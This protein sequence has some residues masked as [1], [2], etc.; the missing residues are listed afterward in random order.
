MTM[1]FKKMGS[2]KA[3]G[4]YY[5][6]S[7]GQDPNLP[8]V[9]RFKE[10]GVD[11]YYQQ[12][13]G[14]EPNGVFLDHKGLLEPYGINHGDE[15]S[16]S[17]FQNLLA[18]RDPLNGD[19]LTGSV[20]E[21]HVAGF[22]CTMSAP[23]PFSALKALATSFERE[24][25]VDR[26]LEIANKA[27]KQSIQFLSENAGYTRRGKGGKIFE[28]VDLISAQWQHSTSRAAD[29]QLHFHNTVFN[30]GFRKDG[31]VGA[32]ESKR[33]MQWQTAAGAVFRAELATGL[34]KEFPEIEIIINEEKG[35]FEIEGINEDLIKFWSK[36][37]NEIEDQM[38][39]LKQSSYAAADRVTL[40]TRE[41][42]TFEESPAELDIR[43]RGEAERF[44]VNTQTLDDILTPTNIKIIDKSPEEKAVLEKQLFEDKMNSVPGLLVENESV[45]TEQQLYRKVAELS[46]GIHDLEDIKKTVNRLMH[47]TQTEIVAQVELKSVANKLTKG[48]V[49]DRKSVK[50]TVRDEV[51]NSQR[52][53]DSVVIQ[54]GENKKG[55]RIFTTLAQVRLEADL[56]KRSHE[57]SNDSTHVVDKKTIEHAITAKSTMS[58]E[59]ADAVRWA[60]SPGSLK[61][62]EGGAGT[63][64]SFSLDVVRQISEENGYKLHGIALSWQAAGVLEASASISSVAITG[65]LNDVEN[66]Q[67]K[68]NNKSILV[69]DENGL[70]GTVYGQK[71]LK[72]VQEAGAK[73]IITGDSNQLNP[74]SAGSAM[75]I[76]L[77]EAGSAKITEI[78]RQKEDWAREMVANFSTGKSTEALSALKEKGYITTLGDR[79][80]TIDR[81]SG[82]FYNYLKNNPGKTALALCGSNSEASDLNMSIRQMK[83]ADGLIGKVDTVIKTEFGDLPFAIGD[84]IMFRKNDKEL[85]ITNRKTATILAIDKYKDGYQINV[86]MED[87]RNLTIDSRKYKGEND[88]LPVHHGDAMTTYSSQGATVDQTFVMHSNSMDRRLAYVAFSRHKEQTNLYIDESAVINKMQS[89]LAA[90]EYAA[91]KPTNND[92]F[93]SVAHQYHVQSQKNTVF[94]YMKDAEIT[95]VLADHPVIEQAKPIIY[96]HSEIN[97]IADTWKLVLDAE[98]SVTPEQEVAMVKV[99][100]NTVKSD[101]DEITVVEEYYVES[102]GVHEKAYRGLRP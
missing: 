79:K 94:E 2:G 7:A 55:Q 54:M 24:D 51:L 102:E 69:C 43:W 64:K 27:N 81:I 71:L 4:N 68:L 14:Q 44:G 49:S 42:K 17:A 1:S 12:A 97:K 93:E 18:G 78:R 95:K 72:V 46:A 99:V 62:V 61:I 58:L 5:I 36:R 67:I 88:A 77:S 53:P 45:F 73:I 48:F 35:T 33:L 82:D 3:A 20:D 84:K 32:I 83:R 31:T 52:D 26:I 50:L 23:K 74:V 37:K 76:M 87:G 19:K 15:V 60:L 89:D 91:F 98:W 6:A 8:A 86:E 41:N 21:K 100:E 57:M 92:I 66:G 13:V 11:D 34:K 56:K 65:F 96:D 39:E 85:D 80:T 38:Q 63:G 28:K 16:V 29:P 90:D 47:R 22:D 59:Q 10:R 25:L 9:E 70:V 30:I 101:N 75:K 40:Q